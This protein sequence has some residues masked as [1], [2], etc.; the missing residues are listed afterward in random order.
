[1]L[2]VTHD[3]QLIA[4][5]PLDSVIGLGGTVQVSGI[6]GGTAA[7]LYYL[8]VRAWNSSNPSGTLSRQWYSTPVDLRSASSANAQLTVN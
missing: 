2:L 3:G 1:V 7:S 4:S 6:P 5:A 8:T